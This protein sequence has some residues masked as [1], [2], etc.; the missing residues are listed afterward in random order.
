MFFFRPA[1]LSATN[2]E[3]FK[4]N[5]LEGAKNINFNWVDVFI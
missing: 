5:F 4:S 3:D 2:N 1:A